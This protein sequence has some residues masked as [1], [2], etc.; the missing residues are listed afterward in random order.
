M[1][2]FI[3][4]LQQN[5]THIRLL[6]INGFHSMC[7]SLWRDKYFWL[8]SVISVHIL[9]SIELN[10][11]PPQNSPPKEWHVLRC[12]Y[13]IYIVAARWDTFWDTIWDVFH[14]HTVSSLSGMKD[15]ILVYMPVF[16]ACKSD[17]YWPRAHLC[18]QGLMQR[19]ST[20]K[21]LSSCPGFFPF[22]FAK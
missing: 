6:C 18:P 2:S 19:I 4:P 8:K 12:L 15:G 21:N 20:K 16:T 9:F 7:F 3:F 13:I 11:T 17:H 22:N 1:V 10:G 14:A 5:D